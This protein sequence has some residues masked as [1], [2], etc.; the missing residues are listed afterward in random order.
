MKTIITTLLF[1]V[2][3][4]NYG[5]VYATEH[6][7]GHG[8][9]SKARASNCLKPR[10]E[11]F[12]PANMATVTPGSEFSFVVFNVESPEHIMVSAKKE[13]VTF[14]TEFKDPFYIVTGKLPDNLRNTVARINIK[15]HNKSSSCTVENG[16]LLK[17]SE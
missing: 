15:V 16:W 3:A 6:H 13:P 7:G 4:F 2:S 14:T 17:I 1:V 8:G 11:K 9:G 12:L 5:L 10:L